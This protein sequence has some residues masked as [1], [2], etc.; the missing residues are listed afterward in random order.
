MQH[1]IAAGLLALA[2]A[3]AASSAAGQR[4]LL[5]V[6]PAA[7]AGVLD[8]ARRAGLDTV[9]PPTAPPGLLALAPAPG[10]PAGARSAAALVAEARRWPGVVAAEEDLPRHFHR[11]VADAPSWAADA[12]SRA[13]APAPHACNAEDEALP[14]RSGSLL[15]EVAPYGLRMI[16]ALDSAKL[17]NRTDDAGVI[18]CVIDRR[19]LAGGEPARGAAGAGAG[20]RAQPGTLSPARRRRRRSGLDGGH[21]DLAR[22][23]LD[24]C[25]GQDSVA[26][27]GC[28]FQWDQDLVNHGTHVAGTVAAQRNGAGSVG[29]V[30]GPAELYVVRVFNDS[31]DVSQG[32]G[33]VYGSTMIL[34]FTQCEGRLAAMQ[35][36]ARGRGGGRRRAAREAA[37]RGDMLFVASSGNNGSA[38]TLLPGR[39][40]ALSADVNPS[41]FP[42]SY[43]EVISV[44]A[45]DCRRRLAKFSQKNPGVDLAAPGVQTLSTASRQWAGKDGAVHAAF[46]ADRP[47]TLRAPAPRA[48]RS[49]VRHGGTGR[50]T[51]VVADCGTG[52]AP[53]PAARGGICLVQYD[54]GLVPRGRAAAPGG[55][56]AREAGAAA[57]HARAAARGDAFDAGSSPPP[58]RAGGAGGAALAPTRFYC[59]AMDFCI[60]QGAAAML[61]APPAIASG[62]YGAHAPAAS[63]ADAPLSATLDC[64]DAGCA[65]WPRIARGPRLPAVGLTLREHAAIRAAAVAGADAGEPL[66]GTVEA[67]AV[68]H[69]TGAIAR[70]WAAFPR[71]RAQEVRA[72]FESTALDLG[73]PGRDS[74]FG[75]GLVQAEAAFVALAAQPCGRRRR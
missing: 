74:H 48:R 71:C 26:P 6:E 13:T 46:A 2:L 38:P 31:G 44:A 68:P 39:G 4:L 41:N 63:Q 50:V 20:R 15:P 34:A 35:A 65:C 10:R 21:P 28:P 5:R 66:V 53:C 52:A 22:N 25:K 45:V 18:V 24:G 42:G 47:S 37:K 69:V 9:L 11:P 49:A 55:H 62:Y 29:V 72:A 17:P 60:A 19:A 16:Q 70:V 57:T 27:A 59:D 43:P 51:G 32:Q 58:T 64:S 14:S 67:Q 56:G 12:G 1:R 40:A 8:A 33:F 7:A 3:L 36:R 73:A 75:H 61:L 54:P 30:P 23:A